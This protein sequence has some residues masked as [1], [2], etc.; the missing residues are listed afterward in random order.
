MRNYLVE[1]C[2]GSTED[3][4]AAAKGGAERA[5]LCSNLFQGGLT[6]T[7]GSFRAARERADIKINVMIRP[8][9]GG[10]RYTEA[11]MATALH[12]ARIFKAAGADGLVCGFLNDDGTV[13]IE[14]TKA[15]V[16]I[17]G[18]IPVTFHRAIDVV[19][20]W[21]EALDQLATIGVRR[22][23]TSGQKSNVL[24]ALD[25]VREMVD[26]A[27]DR[28]IVMPGAGITVDTAEQVAEQTGCAEMHVHFTTQYQDLSTVNNRAIFYGSALYPSETHYPVIDAD[29]VARL[30]R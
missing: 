9:E 15:I 23:L 28:L 4:I 6:P 19:P 10:F 12:D 20:N 1:V 30:N 22:I 5:E 2:C 3:V 17:A 7:L 29:A 18:D 16:E 8:R 26:Y 13:D 21:R 14:R 24:L 25:T 27:G 11:E